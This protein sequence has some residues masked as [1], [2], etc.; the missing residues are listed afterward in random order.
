MDDFRKLFGGA[1]AALILAACAGTDSRPAG[2]VACAPAQESSPP[3][4]ATPSGPTAMN[5]PAGY[6]PLMNPTV[7]M[8][9]AAAPSNV[10]D[11]GAKTPSTEA[12]PP[13]NDCD[14]QAR[15]ARF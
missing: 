10:D 11:S 1:L 9:V 4:A 6:P 3:S 13:R 15:P 14:R 7:P 8:T 2:T 5:P 12:N